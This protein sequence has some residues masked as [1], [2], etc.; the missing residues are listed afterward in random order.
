MG[1]HGDVFAPAAGN[2]CKPT[3]AGSVGHTPIHWQSRGIFCGFTIELSD[4]N[5][6]EVEEH[7][8]PA[9]SKHPSMKA[10]AEPRLVRQRG[11]RWYL[12]IAFAGAWVPWL[13]VYLGG[14]SMND[15]IIQLL[16]AAFVP[17]IAACVVRRWITRQGFANSGV[18]PRLRQSWRSYLIAIS[19]PWGVLVLAIGAGMTAGWS[20]SNI[21]L[22]NSSIIYLAAGPLICIAMSPIFWGEEY[23]WTAY[24]R[25]RLMPGRPFA[26]TFLT[27]TIWGVWHWPLP[28]LGYFGG[29][30]TAIDAI[31]AMILWLPLSI[32][33]EFVI[34]SLWSTTGSVWPGAMVH[35]GSNLVAAQGMSLIL[36]DTF[37]SNITTLLM[38]AGLIPFVVAM[39]RNG[40][41]AAT[42]PATEVE[43]GTKTCARRI[44]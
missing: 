28:W 42:R 6:S 19:M 36:G 2:T 22:S 12:F 43:L 37:N 44:D 26:T 11:L 4:M 29:Q 23:G 34:G 31:W 38:C 13:A 39:V 24:L 3:A 15:P 20:P 1:D 40:H 25:D 8:A 32:L 41:A 17:S 21:E 14:G 27:G 10:L 5:I 35:A 30:T 16:T 9:V 18:H 33:L 7:T